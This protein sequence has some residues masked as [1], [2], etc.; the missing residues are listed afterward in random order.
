MILCTMTWTFIASAAEK[1]TIIV[2][3]YSNVLV[4]ATHNYA[5]NRQGDLLTYSFSTDGGGVINQI[6]YSYYRKAGSSYTGEIET[7]YLPADASDM[8]IVGL[9]RNVALILFDTLGGDRIYMVF[10][11]LVT[12]ATPTP[13]KTNFTQKTVADNQTCS[14]TTNQVLLYNYVDNTFADLLGI[15]VYTHHWKAVN[16]KGI[17]Y[18]PSHGVLTEINPPIEK[19]YKGVI[20][21]GG[22]LYDVQILRP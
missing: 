2:K 21:R 12:N 16:N 5:V 4:D 3:S 1:S 18:N 8:T 19:Y 14:I 9:E 15:T 6:T 17:D 20:D 7:I 11:M 10:R 13:S 22:N